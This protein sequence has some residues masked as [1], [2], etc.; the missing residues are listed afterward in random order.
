MNQLHDIQLAGQQMAEEQYPL[1]L[2][3]QEQLEQQYKSILNRGT[4]DKK[5]KEAEAET[6]ERLVQSVENKKDKAKK[7]AEEKLWSYER[8]KRNAK[9]VQTMTRAERQQQIDY[10]MVRLYYGL[11]DISVPVEF[12]HL[13]TTGN[14]TMDKVNYYNIIL[15]CQA[16]LKKDHPD[17]F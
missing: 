9:H 17:T 15:A 12:Q 11:D 16:Q 3:K 6:L 4:L 14:P 2:Q 10:L 5:Q 8:D 13:V 1:Y 7:E